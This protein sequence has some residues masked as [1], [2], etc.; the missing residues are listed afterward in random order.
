MTEKKRFHINLP[1]TRKVSYKEVVMLS[2]QVATLFEAKVS[3]L[4]TFRLLAQ[5][6]LNPVLQKAL[7]A[8]VDDIKG[9]IRFR[10]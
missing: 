8:I 6:S 7:L 4:A 10:P 9:G 5:E 1:F 3:V 2:R